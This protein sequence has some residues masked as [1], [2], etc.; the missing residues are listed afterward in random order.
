MILAMFLP[1]QPA[2]GGVPEKALDLAIVAS[3]ERSKALSRRDTDAFTSMSS[4]P[5]AKAR[6]LRSILTLSLPVSGFGPPGR[7]PLDGGADEVI[8]LS[9]GGET[10]YS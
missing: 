2:F 8:R 7:R 4:L 3:G 5:D 10:S 1:P 6:R 9:R